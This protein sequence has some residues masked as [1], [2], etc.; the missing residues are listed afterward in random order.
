MF[1]ENCGAK[2]K[3]GAKFCEECGKSLKV[4]K[5]KVVKKRKPLSKKNKIIIGI[6]S[7]LALALIA[8]FIVCSNIY[9]PK[10]VAVNYFEAVVNK[11]Y[12]SL[13]D[14]FDVDNEGF[15]SKKVFEQLVKEENEEDY[16]VINYKVSN[17]EINNDGLSATV[18]IKYVTEDDD[19]EV[20]TIRLVK[21][22][23]NKMLFFGNWKISNA[24]LETIKDYEIKAIKGSKIEVAGIKLDDYLD[25]AKSDDDFDVY[26]LPEVFA[27]EYPV[28]VTYPMGFTIDTSIEP[29]SYLETSSTLTVDS[30][31]LSDETKN[32]IE[33]EILKY[34]QIIYDGA[35]DNKNFSDIRSSFEYENGDLTN[36]ESAYNDFKED[37]TSR[38]TK[39]TEIKFTEAEINYI[40]INDDGALE[41]DFS[42]DYDYKATYEF[43]GETETSEGDGSTYSTMVFAY[44]DGY[45]LIDFDDLKYY[46]Y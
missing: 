29:N 19:D 44:A 10:T 26:V 4:P 27:L 40:D 17:T 9:K 43:L 8:F 36:L 30:D 28:K 7:V 14:Y 16:K 23:K 2:A 45:K 39:L 34:I 24:N 37:L 42:A 32:E 3:E 11:D 13:Y 31:N 18:T 35:K 21:D 41:V 12:D 33:N 38:S 15:T 46:F 6:I 5:K 20:A 22:K 1:C 25:D